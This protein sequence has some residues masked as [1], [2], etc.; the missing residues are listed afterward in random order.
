MIVRAMLRAVGST[1]ALVAIYYLLPLDHSSHWAAVTMLV[2][3]LAALITLITF[4]VRR[5]IASP[6]PG[7]R[8]LEALAT[9]V[10]L[11]LLLFAS[12][13]VVMATLAA[14][15]FSQPMTRTNALYFTVTVF[16][17]VG[18]GDITAKTEAARLVVTGQMIVDLIIIGFGARVIVGAVQRGRQLRPQ[19]TSR[20]VGEQPSP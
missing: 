5:I 16:A 13:Y 14:G 18:F 4:Q 15:N 19:D 9:S 2:I 6:F 10:P 7:L 3:G 8:A 12:T 1:V 17:T 20:T 11:F